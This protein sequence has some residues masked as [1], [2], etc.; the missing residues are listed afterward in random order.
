MKRIDLCIDLGSKIIKITDSVGT[1]LLSEPSVAVVSNESG[2][3]NLLAC[4]SEAYNFVKKRT[5]SVLAYPIK[6]GV[7]DNE[8]VCELMLKEYISRVVPHKL[9]RPSVKA[10]VCVSCGLSNIEKRTI[11]E[12]CAKIGIKDVT[13]VESPLAVSNLIKENVMFIIDFGGNKTELA[14]INDNGIIAGCTIDIGGDT[15]DQA[16]I[17]YICDKYR[18]IINKQAGE[19]I[20]ESIGSVKENDISTV[21]ISGRGVLNRSADTM[22]LKASEIKEAIM[23]GIIKLEEVIESVAYMIPDSILG[24]LVENG[25]YICGGSSQLVGLDKY[26]SDKLK[27]PV[28][29]IDEPI[30][31]TVKGGAKFFSDRNRL[32]KLL[33][34]QKMEI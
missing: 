5:D 19:K 23:P 14:V 33:N 9:I 7:V 6:E 10:I 2:R 16:I 24:E 31:A 3:L 34:I 15:L 1:V 28:N 18:A 26:L 25:F 22:R 11:E 13:V 27:V 8:K 21:T 17:D 4:G 20:K 32:T 30:Y 29:V 12:I